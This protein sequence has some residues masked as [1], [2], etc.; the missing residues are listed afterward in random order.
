M[1]SLYN[2]KLK[3]FSCRF[4][5]TNLICETSKLLEDAVRPL[6]ATPLAR[7]PI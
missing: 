5:Q 6:G 4:N 2:G 7:F 1:G 3:G